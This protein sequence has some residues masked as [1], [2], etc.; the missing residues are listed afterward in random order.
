MKKW[1]LVT[2]FVF[3]AALAGIYIFIPAR[4]EIIQITPVH[5]TTPGS[6][7]SLTTQEKWSSWWPATPSNSN[8][9]LY[10]NNSFEITKTLMNTFEIRIHQNGQPINS[11]LHL[12]PLSGDSTNI[13]WRCSF[14]AGVNPIKRIQHYRQA[15]A[16]KKDMAAILSHFKS[17]AEKKE[18]IYGI[19]FREVIFKDSLLISTKS[20]TASYPTVAD[21]YSLI[22]A[23]KKYSA[24]HQAQQTGS[25]YLNIT[26]LNPFGFQVM[27]AIP[28][29][30][31]IPT[32][33]QFFHRRIPLN[34]FQ[35]TRVH[36]GISTVDQALQQFQLYIQDYR[37][38][39][40][41][42][43]FQQLITDRSAEPDTARWITDIYIPLF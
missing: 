18:N 11:T 14:S 20:T 8:A 36:G 29:D 22:N 31:S 41:A 38:T 34:R 35:V 37:R 10:K 9:F 32:N 17:F 4:L 16:L 33:S 7:R 5:C 19:S 26:P 6:Y 28:V 39:L 25:P 15:V 2:A 24:A 27:T 23:L 43:P 1:L 42:L 30:R 3:I 12:I 13:E 21:I 40:M